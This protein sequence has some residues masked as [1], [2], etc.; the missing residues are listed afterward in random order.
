MTASEALPEQQHQL[1]YPT[2][3]PLEVDSS[4]KSSAE[5]DHKSTSY[6]VHFFLVHMAPKGSIIHCKLNSNGV[7]ILIVRD[8]YLL[9]FLM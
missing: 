9:C 2:T 4:C 7:S 3:M 8:N 1:P 5:K 6:P